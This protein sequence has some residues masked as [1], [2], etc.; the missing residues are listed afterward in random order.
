MLVA[1][2]NEFER[3]HS[4]LT[5]ESLRREMEYQMG[6]ETDIEQEVSFISKV[7]NTRKQAE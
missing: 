1:Q 7:M 3:Y 6:R 5:L 2:I 4:A